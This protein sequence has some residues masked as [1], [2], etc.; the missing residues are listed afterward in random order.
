M[1]KCQQHWL[2]CQLFQHAH[3]YTKQKIN[4][5][6]PY[7]NDKQNKKSLLDWYFI[8]Y[9][10]TKALWICYSVSTSTVQR[11]LI[12]DSIQKQMDVPASCVI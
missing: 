10:N 5:S 1:R 6:G 3:V 7:W 8:K 12:W 11:Q 9:A 2:I 4:S